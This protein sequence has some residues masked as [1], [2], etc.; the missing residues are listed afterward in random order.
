MSSTLS[1]LASA[2]CPA[3]AAAA[4]EHLTSAAGMAQWC[5]GMTGCTEV[6]PGLMFGRSLF[7]ASPAYVRIDAQSEHFTVDY[8]CGASPEALSRRIHARVLPGPLLGYR[9]D[10]C[11]ATLVAWRPA[12]MDDA[13]WQRLVASHEAEILL[14]REQLAARRAS[15]PT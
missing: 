14:V 7:D 11:L 13:R 5:L 1:H 12:G 6:S 15:S 4:F 2:L 9:A 10:E 3:T 8:L